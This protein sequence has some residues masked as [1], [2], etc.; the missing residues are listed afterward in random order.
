VGD[1]LT[2]VRGDRNQGMDL[3][4]PN[5]GEVY[6]VPGDLLDCAVGAE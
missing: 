5:L 4:S 6:E 3:G 1:D 2:V